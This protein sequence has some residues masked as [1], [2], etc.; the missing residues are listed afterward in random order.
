MKFTRLLAFA[1][2]LMALAVVAHYTLGYSLE[3]V[4]SAATAVGGFGAL[5]M[6]M[7]ARAE[8]ASATTIPTAT[9]L[10]LLGNV[11]DL[12]T[13]RNIGNGRQIYLVVEINTAVTSSAA[14]TVQPV[15]VSDAQA[16]I[17]V[18]GTASVHA[19]GAAIA[20]ASL[21]AGFRWVLPVPT[22][23]D[24][25]YERYL[26]VLTNVGTTALT[27]GKAN[28]FLTPDPNESRIY[29]DGVP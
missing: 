25:P 17:A 23:G 14:A 28:A 13:A 7:D 5:G 2:A 15:L 26:G 4:V 16:A 27:A 22:E 20:K 8:F 9:G 1:A 24:I 19:T 12:T 3:T 11:M 10:S 21:V 18:D 6:I 29:A